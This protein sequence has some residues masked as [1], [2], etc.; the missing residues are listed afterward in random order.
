MLFD[1]M[2]KSGTLVSHMGIGVADIG[3]R[4]GRIVADRRP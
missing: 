2:I 4:D 3:M 1:L